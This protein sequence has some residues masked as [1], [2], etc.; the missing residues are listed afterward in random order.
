M[1]YSYL[2]AHSNQLAED[3]DDYKSSN[4]DADNEPSARLFI[5]SPAQISSNYIEALNRSLRRLPPLLGMVNPPSLTPVLSDSIATTVVDFPRIAH[6]KH[7][8]TSASETIF[9]P[10]ICD[11]L[12]PPAHCLHP[13]VMATPTATGRRQHLLTTDASG[14]PRTAAY[15]T[16]TAL[17]QLPLTFRPNSPCK[18]SIIYQLCRRALKVWFDT[19][20]NE[21]HIDAYNTWL[22]P[23]IHA[24]KHIIAKH[25]F[26]QHSNLLAR[27][28]D[29]LPSSWRNHARTLQRD[30]GLTFTR[31]DKGNHLLA[32]CP[33][34][35]REMLNDTMSKA[36]RYEATTLNT[37]EWHALQ[38]MSLYTLTGK[39]YSVFE[40]VPYMRIQ[41]K[42]HKIPMKWRPVC[43]HFKRGAREAETHLLKILT[44]IQNKL[45]R[46]H[47]ISSTFAAHQQV[48]MNA[49]HAQSHDIEG[50]FDAIVIDEAYASISEFINQAFDAHPNKIISTTRRVAT[51]SKPT[52]TNNA[53][54]HHTREQA[55][56][57]LKHILYEDYVIAG[58]TIFHSTAGVGMGMQC[59][60]IISC[61]CCLSIEIHLLPLARLHYANFFY[62]RYC[63][64]VLCSLTP[65]Q[66]HILFDIHFKRMGMKFITSPFEHDGSA[67]F[68]ESSFHCTPTGMHAKH[69][70][71]RYQLFDEADLP[72]RGSATSA[73]AQLR[74]ITCAAIRFYRAN[75]TLS[76]FVNSLILQ[77]RRN[78]KYERSLFAKAFTRILADADNRY[79][80]ANSD[81]HPYLSSI[82]RS[83][84]LPDFCH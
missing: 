26:T 17:M 38:T 18:L 81:T 1:A 31:S 47:V 30:Q 44:L 35:A 46:S 57:L 68:L 59:S 78:P 40:D 21:T 41:A 12:Q 42:D 2:N 69:Y 43:S 71:K 14:F 56:G 55:L 16:A 76:C 45:P 29:P 80:I 52:R 32:S 82:L 34:L 7:E 53:H 66:F 11:A 36:A 73:A 58:T 67:A 9:T 23:L 39:H 72:H 83:H 54:E 4:K 19:F 27:A 49:T 74:Q 33:I 48:P 28:P 77:Q 50:M 63:D 10:C 51:W 20:F 62:V 65:V 61:L 3:G 5:P 79:G 24:H 60:S 84:L 64:D 15:S 70:C 37:A 75:S 8:Y 22:L 25:E 13:H 6:R